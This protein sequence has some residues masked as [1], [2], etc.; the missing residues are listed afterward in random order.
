MQCGCPT[1]ATLM[2]QVARGMD[3][4]CICPNCGH[5]CRDCMGGER[6]KVMIKKGEKIP[7]QIIRQLNREE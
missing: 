4:R 3:S 2:A 7:E 6:F 1:C 5:E